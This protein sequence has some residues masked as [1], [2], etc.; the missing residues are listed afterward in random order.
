MSSL[1]ETRRLTGWSRQPEPDALEDEG[2]WSEPISSTGCEVMRPSR[3]H[4]KDGLTPR[5]QTQKEM[6]NAKMNERSK[7]HE[8]QPRARKGALARD[9]VSGRWRVK[10]ASLPAPLRFTP[11]HG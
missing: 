5:I 11:L 8:R 4:A 6:R 7:D 10:V 3:L 2:L 1:A 9:S